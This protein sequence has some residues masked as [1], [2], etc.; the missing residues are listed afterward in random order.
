MKLLL[1]KSV[2]FM[3]LGINFQDHAGLLMFIE[4][5]NGLI[6]LTIL[7]KFIGNNFAHA[8]HTISHAKLGI[9]GKFNFWHLSA[10]IGLVLPDANA[11]AI[12]SGRYIYS[13]SVSLTSS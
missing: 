7:A 3:I 13:A 4:S 2:L 8:N 6:V 12:V 5:M 9:L 11:N 1:K 10:G